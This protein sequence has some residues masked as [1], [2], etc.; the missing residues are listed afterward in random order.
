M[1]TMRPFAALRPRPGLAAAVAELP[2]DVMS[3]EEARVT[4]R[5]NALSFLRVSKPEID[6]PEGT[7]PHAPAVYAKGRENFESLCRQGVLRQEEHPTLYVYRQAMGQHIQTGIVGVFDCQEYLDGVIRRHELTRPDKE[8]DRVRHLEALNAQTGPAFLTYRSVQ[9]IDGL[10]ARVTVSPAEVDFV[11]KDGIRHTAWVVGDGGIVRGL[12][13]AFRQVPRLYIADGHHRSAAAA[14]VYRS[15][16]GAGGS[17][18]FLAVI[19]PHDQLRILP[20]HRVVRDL[21]GMQAAEFLRRLEGVCELW[22]GAG[23]VPSSRREVAVFL[24]GRWRGVR[25]REE[26]LSGLSAVDCLDVAWLQR[27]VLEPMLGITDPRRSERISFVGG[28]RGTD[29]LERRVTSEGWAVAFSVYPT[30]IGE[31]MDVADAGGL[32]PPKSTWFE[33]KLRDGLFSHV[34]G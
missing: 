17:D 24:E 26:R 32:M 34:L 16:G 11:A 31:L 33:P 2:Y 21:G 4:A 13:E 20:Y 27:E 25:L 10:V 18:R 14:R 3:S 22:E 1:A 15:R 12:V 9:E 28:I 6:L 8:D 23:P 19:F 7:D 29:E 5:G 30:G